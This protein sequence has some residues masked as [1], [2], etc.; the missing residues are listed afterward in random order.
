MFHVKVW[1][2]G[3]LSEKNNSFGFSEDEFETL[4]QAFD[5]KTK[6][7]ERF[8][9]FVKGE[10]LHEITDLKS[11]PEWVKKDKERK[12]REAC[13]NIIEL[14]EILLLKEEGDS[15]KLEALLQLRASLRK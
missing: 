14:V 6:E 5:W 11:N 1:C 3:I 13:P 15:S 9:A 10:V 8:R 4:E 12:F 2:P 7:V